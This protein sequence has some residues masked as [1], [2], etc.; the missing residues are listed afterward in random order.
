MTPFQTQWYTSGNCQVITCTLWPW[1]TRFILITREISRLWLNDWINKSM[2]FQDKPLLQKWKWDAYTTTDSCLV[3]FFWEWK[4]YKSSSR[5]LGFMGFC[6][7]CLSW[8]DLPVKQ[9]KIELFEVHLSVLWYHLPLHSRLE[10][11]LSSLRVKTALHRKAHSFL[12]LISY[13]HFASLQ[14]FF[15]VKQSKSKQKV[16]TPGLNL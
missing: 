15:T 6:T 10:G 4:L 1:Q 12:W 2:T 3:L 11:L 16:A 5:Y 14:C 7:A 13:S 9:K 8:V